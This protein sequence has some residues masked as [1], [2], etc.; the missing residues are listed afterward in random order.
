MNKDSEVEIL[1]G[2][3][4]L[5]SSYASGGGASGVWIVNSDTP[6]I[7]AGAG[8]GANSTTSLAH[9]KDASIMKNGISSA[10]AGGINGNGGKSGGQTGAGGG[11]NSNGEKKSSEGGFALKSGGNGGKGFG[12]TDTYDGSFGFGGGGGGGGYSGGGGGSYQKTKAVA[13]GGG[14]GS[15]NAGIN[16]ANSV[17]KTGHGKV[18][19]TYL[20]K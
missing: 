1:V 11:W 9:G 19:I 14:G 4:G 2:Q 7:I 15:F 6:M 12:A 18:I 5:S 3:E 8:G 10:G 16:Q 17:G 13:S 20:G